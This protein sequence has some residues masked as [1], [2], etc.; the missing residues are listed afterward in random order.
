MKRTIV[1]AAKNL[2]I[3]K[4]GEQVWA[5]ILI[6]TGFNK[7]KIFFLREDIDDNEVMKLLDNTAKVTGLS[8]YQVLEAF[9]DHWVNVHLPTVYPHIHFDDLKEYILSIDEIHV[10]M[11]ESVPGA[12]PPR[13]EYEWKSDK[14]LIMT[15]KSHRNLIDLVVLILRKLGEK[16][17]EKIT[18]EKIDEKHLRIIF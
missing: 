6:E 8:L 4:F 7:N 2:V 16:Y 1:K 15:Y 17:N 5:K 9:A 3:S 11:T 18:V 12:K 13:F 14:E 10:M